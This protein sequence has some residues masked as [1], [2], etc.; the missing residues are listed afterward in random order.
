MNNNIQE[1]LCLLAIMFIIM[2]KTRAAV[3]IY[4]QKSNIRVLRVIRMEVLLS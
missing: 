4:H 3:N 2:K 1:T